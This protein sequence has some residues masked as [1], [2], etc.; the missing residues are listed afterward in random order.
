[1][2]R[3]GGGAQS[4][5]DTC[6][7]IGATRRRREGLR[8]GAAKAARRRLCELLVRGQRRDA[9]DAH[10]TLTGPSGGLDYGVEAEKRA[11]R[12]FGR[13]AASEEQPTEEYLNTC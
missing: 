9:S 13:H 10:R 6:C 7:A 8:N 2:D 11:S 1:M 3:P 12:S 5:V 4:A